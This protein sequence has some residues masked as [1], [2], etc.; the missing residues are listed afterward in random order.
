M[1]FIVPIATTL[2]LGACAH[3]NVK[4][5]TPSAEAAARPRYDCAVV[6]RTHNQACGSL[7]IDD[8]ELGPTKKIPQFRCSDSSFGDNLMFL[9]LSQPAAAT[10]VTTIAFGTGAYSSFGDA[11][12]VEGKGLKIPDA[13]TLSLAV[14]RGATL[15]KVKQ[16]YV[17]TC[18]KVR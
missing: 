2:L 11:T 13:F 7:A 8:D 10:G 18:E 12:R 1:K 6:D 9:V 3:S 15:E 4:T 16:Q 5:R 17:A 14:V